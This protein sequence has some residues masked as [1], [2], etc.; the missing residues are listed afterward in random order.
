VPEPGNPKVTY[1]SGYYSMF[2]RYDPDTEQYRDVT[3]WPR[4]R[5]GAAA[6]D[7][8]QRL[9]WTHPIL[10]SPTNPKELL[11]GSQYVMTSED[12][13]ASWRQISPDLTRNDKSTQ[14]PSGGPV[15]L[16]QTGVE[17]YPYIEALAVSPLDGNVIWAG[18]ADG[19]VHVTTDHGRTWKQ[20]S[21]TLPGWA[22]ISS[23]EP[24][25]VEKGTAYLTASRYMW[26]DFAPYVFKTTDF[27]RTWTP[28]TSGLPRDQYA[29]SVKQDPSVPNL[30]FLGT[31]NTAFA[32][33]DGGSNWR[34]LTL[35]LPH[36]Q[37]R[38]IAINAR[39]GALVAATHGRAFWVLDNLALL[40]QLTRTP[41]SDPGSTVLFA[42]ERAWLTNAYGQ[43]SE[44]WQAEGA[45]ENPPFGATVYF[46]VP[47][48][49]DGRTPV[50]L[51]FADS[52]GTVIRSF[53]LHRKAKTGAKDEQAD[54]DQKGAMQS[55]GREARA[56]K[57]AELQANVGAKGREA[58]EEEEDN[59]LALPADLKVK[60]Q[61]KA[62]AIE[63]GMNAFRWNLRYPD[64]TDVKGFYTINSGG[65][66]N[67]V[68]GPVVVPGTYRVMLDY[69]GT[70]TQQQFEVALDPR[71]KSN[72]A[73][74]NARFALLMQIHRTLD[75]LDRSINQA[76]AARNRLAASAQPGSAST[77]AALNAAIA[78]LVQLESQ[79][80]EGTVLHPIR[81]RSEL[82]YLGSEIELAWTRPAAGQFA[83]FK[84]LD[85]E[86]NNGEQKIEALLASIK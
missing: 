22:E 10:F 29:L 40:E 80:D 38:D 16:D 13:G 86:A 84:Q 28:I 68:S 2:M 50:R 23:I 58:E 57:S 14:G 55:A 82:A 67:D 31:K 12:N 47:M 70:R 36:A 83:V 20:I 85:A 37:V 6:E 32:S 5:E 1:G 72:A 79:S 3:A 63:P 43:P 24:S 19:L 61:V 60:G 53:D 27:G 78:D 33:F 69:G 39:Q 54:Q 66:T 65:I 62:T 4:Y 73:D 75:Q 77:I 8:E 71:I 76:I 74:L 7:Q 26:D 46:R 25:H 81:L 48:S 9:A 49:Y 15:E 18:S 52:N 17:T 56:G 45:G 34:P 44:A 21:P 41:P 64:A 35:N 59:P 51:S 42:P 30:L 11:V